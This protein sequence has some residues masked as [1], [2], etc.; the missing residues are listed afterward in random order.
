MKKI[1]ISCE[2]K[3]QVFTMHKNIKY[4]REKNELTIKQMAE[5]MK[6]SEKKLIRAESC[7]DTGCFYAK[8]I[9]NA[10]IYFN[11]SADVLMN[12]KLY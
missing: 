5:I 3:E 1:N 10:C 4:L 9:T 12:E 6:I 7:T 8:H 2:I 11:V